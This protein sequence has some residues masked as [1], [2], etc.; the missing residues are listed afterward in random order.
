MPQTNPLNFGEDLV[1][2]LDIKNPGNPE[3]PYPLALVKFIKFIIST[4][5]MLINSNFIGT[6]IW[7]F[8]IALANLF[9]IGSKF[10]K[11]WRQTFNI[12]ILIYGVSPAITPMYFTDILIKF[13]R[14]VKTIDLDWM[15]KIDL[16]RT[17]ITDF[18][19][20]WKSIWS[21]DQNPI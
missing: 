11:L 16:D 10:R 12:G 4:L 18:M 15:A 8:A 14:H 21:T 2:C 5:R 3:N 13:G 20:D 9:R 6:F 17:R 1:C 19:T 7:S